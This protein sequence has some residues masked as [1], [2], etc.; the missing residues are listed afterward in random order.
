MIR[1]LLKEQTKKIKSKRNLRNNMIHFRMM[2][3]KILKLKMRL[4]IKI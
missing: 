2:I 3:C 1:L 4:K